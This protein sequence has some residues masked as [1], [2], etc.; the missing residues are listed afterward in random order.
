[1][2]HANQLQGLTKSFVYDLPYAG[3]GCKGERLSEK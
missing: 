3:I 2:T 1:M